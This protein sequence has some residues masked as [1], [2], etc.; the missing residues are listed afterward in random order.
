MYCFVLHAFTKQAHRKGIIRLVVTQNFRKNQGSFISVMEWAPFQCLFWNGNYSIVKLMVSITSGVSLRYRP[1]C[2]I[3]VKLWQRQQMRK[4]YNIKVDFLWL[5][6]R[7][8]L[9]LGALNWLEKLRIYLQIS[10]ELHNNILRYRQF[11]VE[12]IDPF[13][14]KTLISSSKNNVDIAC[15]QLI[16]LAFSYN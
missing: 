16:E 5:W 13:Y 7:Y 2:K 9:S 3:N 10:N 4:T 15:A 11:S 8:W 1:C 14:F 12:Q 6:S